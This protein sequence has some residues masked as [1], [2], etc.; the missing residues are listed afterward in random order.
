MLFDPARHEPLKPI[1]WNADQAQ[2]ALQDI[3]AD[4][5]DHFNGRGFW[6][7]HPRDAAAYA[8]G[9]Q[10]FTPLYKGAC[11]V[12]WALHYLR[13]V[14]A[15]R[16][17][18]DY[19]PFLD[20]VQAA[21]QQWLGEV[22][23]QAAASYL[24]GDTPF[25]MLR[26]AQAPGD[27]RNRDALAQLIAGN[28]DH[29]HRELMWGAP[30]TQLA[31]LLLHERGGEPLWAELFRQSAARLREQLL[32][33]DNFQC[34]YWTQ[35]MYG[36]QSTYL[37]GI[38]GFAGTA[39]TL[40]KGRHLLAADDWAQWQRCIVNTMARTAS[41]KD[42]L[43]NWRAHL[44]EPPGEAPRVL[45]QFCH[46]APGF[47]ICLAELPGRELDSLLLQAGEA[48]WAAGPL[49]KG[50]N[51][52]HGTGGNGYAFL[53]LHQRTGDALW[54]QRARAFAMHGIAQVQ[55][56]RAK[57]GQGQYSLWSG[58]LGFAAYLRDCVAGRPQFPTLDAFYPPPAGNGQAP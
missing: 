11:G 24:M 15:V 45:M 29:P 18:R 49:P 41:V 10:A 27:T 37:D 58:D 13:D 8:S 52:C 14:G 47:V 9:I 54:L 42:G 50:A 16:L 38:H 21:N 33:S 32:W 53:K 3:A 44:V 36:R 55:A 19:L 12:I 56:D 6:P 46:G 28:M 25:L 30:G 34:H 31:A 39:F 20:T 17:R 23:D 5:E 1:P 35:D 22:R 43:A 7:A 48:V 57:Y 26:H 40:I 2:A 51:L 4:A